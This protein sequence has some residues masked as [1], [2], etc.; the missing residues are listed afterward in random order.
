MRISSSGK[1]TIAC[2]GAAISWASNGVVSKFLMNEGLP[3]FILTQGRMTFSAIL[4]LL[5]ILFT[6]PHVLIIRTRDILNFL[7]LGSVGMAAISASYLTAISKIPVAAAILLQYLS[8]VLIAFY[9]FI[10]MNEE[11]RY[12]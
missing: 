9:A 2:L 6:R 10:F 12:P 4:I 3:P 5:F 8:P 11:K 1:G 7:I